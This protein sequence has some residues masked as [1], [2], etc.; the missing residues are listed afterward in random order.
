MKHCPICTGESTKMG[1]LGNFTW[2]RCT[3]CGMQQFT[4]HPSMNKPMRKRR[5][6]LSTQ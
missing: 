5:A 6:Q 3:A 2:Y 4:T 1:K